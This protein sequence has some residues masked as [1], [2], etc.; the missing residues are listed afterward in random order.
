MNIQNFEKY[1]DNKILARGID[2][3]ESGYVTS[4][5]YDDGE[6]I[7]EVEGSEDYT[8]SVTISDNREI[9]ES[10][11][12]CPYDW[13]S[14]CKH[15]VAAFFALR[16]NGAQSKSQNTSK[17]ESLSDI[18]T[19]L[20][21]QTLIALIIEYA[22]IYKPIKSEIELRY[23]TKID[24][25]K[26]ARDII[27]SSINAVKH[28]GYVEYRYI[29][30]ATDGADTVLQMI[31]DKIDANELLIAVSLGI[32]IVEEMMDL[33]DSCDDSNGHVGRAI[34]CAVDKI[35]DAVLAMPKNH[36]DSKNIFD[37]IMT[38]ALSDKYN[39]WIDWRMSLL[40][41]L[42]PLCYI[43]EN[44]EQ[45]EGYLTAPGSQKE[46]WHQDY[47]LRQKQGILLEITT[48]YDGKSAAS[49]YIEENLDNID[50]RNMA[51]K[52][53]MERGDY[54]K[55]I[56]LCIEGEE[57]NIQYPG[58]VKNLKALRYTAYNASGKIEEQKLLSLEILLDGDFGYY[59]KYKNLWSKDEWSSVISDV[60]EKAEKTSTRD[61][62]LKI[63]VHEKL[64]P[65]ILTYCRKHPDAIVNYHTHLLPE[66]KQE[67]GQIFSNYI[68][69]QA[70]RANERSQYSEICR[71]IKTCDK[72]C[73][74]AT[75]DVCAEIL[76]KYAKRPA[77]M[78][79]MRKIGK[80]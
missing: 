32:I 12:D 43:K 27:R 24:I 37:T 40:S 78:D 64:K 19:K 65:R 76:F 21:K 75:D 60:L 35:Q 6:W 68:R 74:G 52:S 30:A 26:S 9:L 61:L 45:L 73:L 56:S 23:A 13:G 42:V 80:C 3:Y 34:S 72:A 71:L 51:I 47:D 2:Y 14:Y 7:A 59:L 55:V 29:N 20:D 18:L 62:Y 66:Y 28:R 53:A 67:V 10:F 22:K 36:K 79:E 15:Q 5:E 50:F 4:L 41:A 44:R 33:M 31:E 58:I 17:K 11:C 54:S 69:Q 8:V 1:V 38:H 39:G 48:L 49:K 70:Q 57:S 46:I 16:K 77:F 63:I 25:T